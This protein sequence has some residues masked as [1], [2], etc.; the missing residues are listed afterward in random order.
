VSSSTDI[1][2]LVI[3]I[4]EEDCGLAELE[5]LLA[6]E[7]ELL[8][9]GSQAPLLDN[10]SLQERTLRR[11]GK[12]AEQRLRL[13]EELLRCGA[14]PAAPAKLGELALLLP[15]PQSDSVL[16]LSRSVAAH[17]ESIRRIGR[18]NRRLIEAG[19]R[20]LDG[21]VE[22]LVR[23]RERVTYAPEDAV[24]AEARFF[25]SEA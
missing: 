14:L 5:T 7:S 15:R 23:P 25:S 6:S 4:E 17:A 13:V 3:N 2:S 9:A 12:L 18:R 20:C 10:L 16:N 8:T 24:P 21:I 22:L 19:R 1:D 11:L